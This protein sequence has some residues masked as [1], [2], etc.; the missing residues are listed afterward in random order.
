MLVAERVNSQLEASGVAGPV[1][2][3][4][5]V[6]FLASVGSFVLYDYFKVRSYSGPRSDQIST[7]GLARRVQ[8]LK[9]PPHS[10]GIP[11]YVSVPTYVSLPVSNIQGI[12]VWIPIGIGFGVGF[13]A[14]LLGAGGG[15][16]LMPVMFFVLGIPTAVAVGTGLLQITITG[17]VG[18]VVY[19]LSDKVDVLMVVIMLATASAGSQIGVIATGFVEGTRI[20]SLFGITILSASVAV[21]L[22]Q[23]SES[24][25]IDALSTAAAILLLSV[26]G[27]VCVAIALML[28]LSRNVGHGRPA[29]PGRGRRTP[30]PNR[31]TAEKEVARMP[32][33]VLLLNYTD[34]G[35]RNI[36]Y[37]PQ[38]VSAFRQAIE[39]AGG[40]VPQILL[41]LGQYDLVLVIEA[42]SDQACI[43]MALGLSSLGNVRSTTL[44]AFGEYEMPEIADSIPSLEDEF[45]RILSALRPT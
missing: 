31:G 28:L 13:L 27:A 24:S 16:I 36:K 10:I 7:G 14:G 20:R 30:P 1:I 2:S 11:G 43:S 12:S 38:H 42:P 15:F 26:A 17:L 40:K 39:A 35:M 8:S 32:S 41:T 29:Q 4:V 34:E 3:Y 25:D 9:I 18:T 6:A 5:Y 22:R 33:Y 19:S 23:V 45:A 44:K 37:L 21:A